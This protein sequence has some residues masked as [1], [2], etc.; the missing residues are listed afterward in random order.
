MGVTPN[1][2][3]GHKVQNVLQ[4][5]YGPVVLLFKG[6]C[7]HTGWI[8]LQ[9]KGLSRVFSSTTVR[10]GGARVTAGP[11]RPHLSVCPGWGRIK[12]SK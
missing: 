9:F 5:G 11:K 7:F 10:G 1:S 4:L 8:S 6:A 12:G 2:L 3:H